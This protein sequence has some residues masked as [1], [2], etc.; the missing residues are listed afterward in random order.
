MSLYSRGREL[1]R[2]DGPP[3]RDALGPAGLYPLVILTTLNVVDEL[4]HAVIAVFAPN[5]RRYFGLSNA[6][7]GALVGVHLTVILVV[8]VPVGYWATK[9]DRTRVLR[10]SAVAW[11]VASSATFFALRLPTF[12]ATRL[13]TGIGKAAVDPVGKALLTDWYPPPVWNRV[14]AIHNAANPLGTI[15]GPLMAGVIGLIAAGDDAWRWAYP[16]LTVPTLFAIIAARR[17]QEPET[18]MVKAMG[19]QMLTVTMAP[20]GLTFRQACG[21]LLHIRTFRSQ[22]VG[23]G[24]LGFGL[25]GAIAFYSVL[26][27]EEFGVGEGGRGLATGILATSSLLG[28]LIGGRVGER[29][30]AMSP[31]RSVRLVGASVAAFSLVLP[32]AV[33]MPNVGLFVAVMW[34]GI[35]F[36]SVALSP[37]GAALSAVTPP[38]LRPLMFALLGVFIALFG[39]FLG[40]VF[41]GAVADAAGIRIG[42]ASLAP[43]GVVGGI[44]MARGA[45]TIDADIA[46]MGDVDLVV[47]A[48]SN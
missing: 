1:L 18:Q 14:I 46:A 47:A 7:L 38:R 4:D 33:A 3:L 34:V 12:V 9:L 11:S 19:A 31:S 29:L 43:F 41:V 40:G 42:L 23:I 36:V 37:L 30:F 20:H 21:R 25:I 22:A 13:G 48:A 28:T 45:S 8:G 44:L 17:L 2:R 32:V 10:W 39:G 35:L 16:V 6:E 27:E 15:V 5:I 24:V 26:L